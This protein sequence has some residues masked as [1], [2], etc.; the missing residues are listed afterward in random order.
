M[1]SCTEREPALNALFDGE[2]DSLNAS[3]V[4]EQIRTCPTCGAYIAFLSDVREAMASAML[5]DAAPA[6]LRWRSEAQVA[7]SEERRVPPKPP[8]TRRYLPW[9]GGG[10]VGALAASLALMVSAPQLGAPPFSE[11]D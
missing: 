7:V 9:F 10:A 11:P 2:L 5:D 4:E 1:T 3:E 6:A 8:A